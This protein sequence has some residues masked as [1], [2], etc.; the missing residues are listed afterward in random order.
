MDIC[1]KDWTLEQLKK[2][3][4]SD[5]S[6]FTLFQSDGRI[7]SPDLNPIENL[8]DVLEKALRSGPTLP[9]SIQDLAF[10]STPPTVFNNDE[11]IRIVMVGKTG[12]GKSATGNTI[13]GQKCFKSGF[14][15]KSLTQHCEKA[16]GEVDGQSIAVVDTPGWFYT[17]N[18][19]KE[20]VKDIAQ[21]ISYA[22]PGP[23]IFLVVIKLGRFTEEERQTVQKI[24][25]IFGEKA[26]KYS[27]VLFTHGDQLRGKS[28]EEFLKESEDL[29]ELVAKYNNQYHVFNN[30]VKYPLQVSELLKKIGNINVQNGGSYYTTEMFQNAERAIEEEKQ[31]ILKEKEE[32]HRNE[33][34]ELRKEIE[35]K[36]QQQLSEVCPSFLALRCTRPTIYNN[37]EL[38][39][40]VMV[41]K[42]GVGKSASGNT[43]LGQRC[44][45]S[46]FSPES[47]TTHCEKAVGEVNGQWVAVIDTPGMFD[48]RNTEEKTIQD[49]SQ[50]IA[51]A[52]PGPHIFLVVI[53]LGRFTEEEKQTVQKIQEIFGEEANKYSMVLFTHGDQLKGKPIEEFLKNS[54]DLQELVAKCN[55]QYHVFNKEMEDRS[56]V[57]KL[58]EKIKKINEQNGG[59]YYTTEM[60]QNAERAI[61]EEKQQILK[62]R[63]EQNRKE[64]EELLKIIEE[65]YERQMR[66]EKAD[67]G[68]GKE[69]RETHDREKEEE[70]KKKKKQQEEQARRKAEESPSIIQWL[71]NGFVKCVKFVKD[72]MTL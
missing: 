48:T 70:I 59:S 62:E 13:L 27:M 52:S 11:V 26:N 69:L 39:R 4:W 43:I 25:K 68:R 3:M 41:G 38:I 14:S 55:G 53:K 21:C 54:K 15:P 72:F 47:L 44:F 12:V 6:R 63:E 40:I 37:D 34:E 31:Q 66:E 46:Q 22:S 50:S 28:I 24:Q 61:E 49:I 36:Y 10:R 32:E 56:Q 7:R 8:W 16:V 42:T 5:E 9:S 35:E 2:V 20:T 57:S 19:K 60:F 45:K 18:T 64:Q 67:R 1:H 71:V 29:Q 17:R 23:H 65:K 58:L 33:Q 51:Y 30:D